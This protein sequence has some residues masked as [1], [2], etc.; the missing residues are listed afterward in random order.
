[1]IIAGVHVCS[2]IMARALV[3][4]LD[5]NGSQCSCG[6]CSARGNI[7]QLL[8]NNIALLDIV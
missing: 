6:E 5:T 2:G 8:L 4:Q 7:V 1:M 3:T